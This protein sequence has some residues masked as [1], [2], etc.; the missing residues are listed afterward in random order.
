MSPQKNVNS[1]Q[2]INE[3]L[4]MMQ[5]AILGSEGIENLHIPINVPFTMDEKSQKI[6][7]AKMANYE[8]PKDFL[9][10]CV[11]H[12]KFLTHILEKE[13]KLKKVKLITVPKNPK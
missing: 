8:T 13:L 11:N 10:N 5:F 4:K 6:Y 12:I 7:N 3:T 9:I 1:L 2:E